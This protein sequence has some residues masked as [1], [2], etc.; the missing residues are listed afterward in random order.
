MGRRK[1][2]DKEAHLLK[3]P[4]HPPKRSSCYK[5]KSFKKHPRFMLRFQATA[6]K[7]KW[8]LGFLSNSPCSYTKQLLIIAIC[9]SFPSS[10]NFIH[11]ELQ[12][13]AGVAALKVI[14]FL[15]TFLYMIL[16]LNS[17][18]FIYALFI[19]GGKFGRVKKLRACFCSLLSEFSVFCVFRNKKTGNQKCFNRNSSQKHLPNRPY[20][21]WLL[22]SK[23][24][25]FD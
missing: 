25:V 13:M 15:F 21:F 6:V 22:C 5:T 1:P 23:P 9:T 3:K 19:P 7:P 17:F 20:D 10:E 18:C 16:S 12:S 2:D 11:L 24:A 14:I 4:G 8:N